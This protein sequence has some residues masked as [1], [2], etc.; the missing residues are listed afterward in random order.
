MASRS[1]LTVCAPRRN[2]WAEASSSNLPN[3]KVRAIMPSGEHLII[4]FCAKWPDFTGVF[5]QFDSSCFLHPRS[6]V[7]GVGC[8]HYQVHIIGELLSSS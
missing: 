5:T 4:T 7:A 8:G 6:I 2:S 1:I 3:L